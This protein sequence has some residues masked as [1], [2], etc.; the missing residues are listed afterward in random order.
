MPVHRHLWR[1]APALLLHPGAMS[2][3][4]A[5]ANWRGARVPFCTSKPDISAACVTVLSLF[6][7][8]AAT[9]H[10]VQFQTR[11]TNDSRALFLHPEKPLVSPL[12][13]RDPLANV[14]RAILELD[15]VG[16]A[17]HKK[18]DCVLVH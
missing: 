16:L 10:A 1:Q 3:R 12:L 2:C 15:V 13:S 8:C 4:C 6:L 5:G 11:E 14:C 7:L 9:S 17:A 18:T